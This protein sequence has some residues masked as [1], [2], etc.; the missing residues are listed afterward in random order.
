MNKV[1]HIFETHLIYRWCSHLYRIH[2]KTGMF[3]KTTKELQHLT[4]Y[5]SPLYCKYPVIAQW[6]KHCYDST[7][8]YRNLDE[9]NSHVKRTCAEFDYSSTLAV[10][11]DQ[12]AEMC[13]GCL[14]GSILK[15]V[16]K[17]RC[18]V[19]ALIVFQPVIIRCSLFRSLNRRYTVYNKKLSL[20]WFSSFPSL[21]QSSNMMAV[22][23][24]PIFWGWM[25]C[26]RF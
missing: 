13:T 26:A 23:V 20:V 10:S 25:G 1:M 14:Q 9:Y 6:K 2:L 16:G 3:G 18:Y 11:R 4:T 24:H 15:T 17:N 7:E 21:P 12:F 22:R 5:C 19:Q 8:C